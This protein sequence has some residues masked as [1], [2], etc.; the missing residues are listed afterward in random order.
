M[1]LGSRNLEIC[2][3]L[4]SIVIASNAFPQEYI[5]FGVEFENPQKPLPVKVVIVTMFEIGEDVGDRAGEFQ[6]WKERQGLNVQIAF[7]HSHHDLFYNEDT[8]VLGIVTGIGTA[9]SASAIMALGLDSR[10]DL[11]NAYWIIAGIAG[12]DPEDASIGSV[13]WS[14]Y[15]VDGDL[16]HEIDPR[17]MPTNWDF[18]Y[19]ARNTTSPFDPKKPEPTGEVFVANESLRDWAF[20]QTKDIVLPD[21][22]SLEETR[23]LY[24]EHPNA[25]KPPFV[26]KGGHIAAM[27]FWH[28]EILNEWANRWVEYW[29]NGK[30][31]FVTSAMEDTGTFQSLEYLDRIDRVDKNRVMVLRAGSNYTMQPPNMTAAENMLK[32]NRG[33][34]GLEVSLESLYLVGSI[35]LEEIVHKWDTYKE[36]IPGH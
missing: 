36:S 28:G 33:F 18:G 17:E 25:R 24:T 22:R 2:I 16:A 5:P 3:Y 14:S 6:L 8:Q 4:V 13:A 21:S 29:T 23:M 26:L 11:S 12:I 34:A 27:T 9:K 30:T 10:L 7:P 19:F 35:V 32:E 1:L 31:D 20:D 15:L